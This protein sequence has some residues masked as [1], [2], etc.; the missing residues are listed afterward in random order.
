MDEWRIEDMPKE[1][2]GQRENEERINEWGEVH[3][4]TI[5]LL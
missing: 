2:D 4:A 5:V 3:I 1:R